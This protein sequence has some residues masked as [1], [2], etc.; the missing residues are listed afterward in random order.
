MSS[1]SK[2]LYLLGENLM[3]AARISPTFP[4]RHV[5][6][7]RGK[8]FRVSVPGAGEFELR[9]HSSD[10]STVRQVFRKREYD[11]SGFPQWP[12]IERHY[13]ALL[14]AGK[15]P[16]IVDAGANIGAASIWF[17]A[18]F[19]KAVVVAVEPDAANA[20]ACRVNI[21]QHPSIRLV[22]AAIGATPGFV[23][24]SNPTHEA[25]AVQTSRS[26]VAGAGVKICTIPELVAS[27]PGAELFI[28]KI[29]IEGFE[30][31]LF[32]NATEWVGNTKVIFIEP[33]DWMS[34]TQGSSHSFQRTMGSAGFDVL[35]SGENLTYVRP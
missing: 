31:D 8:P 30:S 17:A 16:L 19:P 33:H 18:A 28:V 32:S 23:E 4:L 35:I 7:M 3:D 25:W 27:V 24:M 26:D 10:A 15:T 13:H 6:A 5:A 1:A 14:A 12:D 21:A 29:D 2:F 11:I 9:P 22:E 20:A 34:S